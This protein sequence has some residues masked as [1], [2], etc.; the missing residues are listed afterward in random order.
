MPFAL[1]GE[2]L[3]V[4]RPNAVS[5]LR[6]E[7]IRGIAAFYSRWYGLY[8]ACHL[9]GRKTENEPCH[10]RLGDGEWLCVATPVPVATRS[11]QPKKG[12]KLGLYDKNGIKLAEGVIRV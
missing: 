6:G 2:R 11:G 7:G 1:R 8:I 9:A 4:R 12:D 5:Y 3:Y 10:L